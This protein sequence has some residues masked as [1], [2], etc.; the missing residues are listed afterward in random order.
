MRRAERLTVMVSSAVHGFEPLLDQVFA[1]FQG[2]GYQV[3]MSYKGTIPVH[4]KK[5]AFQSCLEA[6]L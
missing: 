2:F 6:H 5:S 1:T 4:P 3:W